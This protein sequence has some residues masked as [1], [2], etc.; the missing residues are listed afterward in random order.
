MTNKK[1]VTRFKPGQAPK[2]YVACDAD[3]QS[4]II[5]NRFTKNENSTESIVLYNNHDTFISVEEIDRLP[6]L[7]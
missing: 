4:F 7:V 5:A 6:T 2:H 1:L 3:I